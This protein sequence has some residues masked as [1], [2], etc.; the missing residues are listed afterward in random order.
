[1]CPVSYYQIMREVK[2]KK[3]QRYR[4]VIYAKEH[5]IKP[6][7]RVYG[8]TPKT[9]RKWVK[10][11]KQGNYQALDDLSRRPRYCPNALKPEVSAYIVKLRRK[12][13]RLGAQQVKALENLPQSVKTI[14]KQ[15][16][17][18]GISSRMRRKKHITKQ[19]LREVKKKFKLFERSCEDTKDLSDIPE[20]LLLPTL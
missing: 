7:S 9:V 13:K 5:G 8:T 17:K 16:R 10:R 14:R 15:W 3:Q 1:M 6:A 19:N 2:D 12:Y 4:I 11:F 20:Y 18:A